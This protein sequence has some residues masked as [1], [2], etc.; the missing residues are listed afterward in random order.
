MIITDLDAL[1]TT[2]LKE[3]VGPQNVSEAQPND[4]TLRVLVAQDQVECTL[5]QLT[6]TTMKPAIVD[7]LERK[8]PKDGGFKNLW[9]TFKHHGDVWTG[10]CYVSLFCWEYGVSRT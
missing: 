3:H 9:M 10:K 7:F 5:D 2:C 6:P 1:G 8:L 4:D